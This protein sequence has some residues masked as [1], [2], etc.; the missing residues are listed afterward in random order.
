VGASAPARLVP[1]QPKQQETTPPEEASP[2]VLPEQVTAPPVVSKPVQSAVPTPT[3][4]ANEPTEAQEYVQHQYAI[5]P[6]P[7]PVLPSEWT[8]R[9]ILTVSGASLAGVIILVVSLIF[10]FSDDDSKET[11]SPNQGSVEDQAPVKND[12]ADAVVQDGGE[13]Q[14]VRPEANQSKPSE[15]AGSTPGDSQP[16]KKPPPD[17]SSLSTDEKPSLPDFIDLEPV[18]GQEQI[19]TEF[20]FVDKLKPLEDEGF[21]I[22]QAYEPKNNN[23]DWQDSNGSVDAL[24]YRLEKKPESNPFD[25]KPDQ[26]RYVFIKGSFPIVE[27]SGFLSR[28][29]EPKLDKSDSMKAYENAKITFLSSINELK[30]IGEKYYNSILQAQKENRALGEIVIQ[31]SKGNPKWEPPFNE[32]FPQAQI[33][34][35]T[36]SIRTYTKALEDN[37]KEITEIESLKN[38][39]NELKKIGTLKTLEWTNKKKPKSH[40]FYISAVRLLGKDSGFK[41]DNPISVAGK[42]N[43][44]LDCI[45]N[46]KNDFKKDGK[47]YKKDATGLTKLSDAKSKALNKP[48]KEIPLS[49]KIKICKDE[50]C[51]KVKGL[52]S[53]LIQI[54]E[55]FKIDLNDAF[56]RP[57]TKEQVVGINNSISHYERLIEALNKIKANLTSLEK[58]LKDAKEPTE[59]REGERVLLRIK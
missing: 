33:D 56:D 42:S 34:L 53:K 50:L 39:R 38:A 9:K 22:R 32:N 52:N 55:K 20:H 6:P 43:D 14:P 46:A 13:T 10:L 47:V 30:K 45:K 2:E 37:K 11:S 59:V 5:A 17:N 18:A 26:I 31:I 21:D 35:E 44:I 15:I 28:G 8:T 49:E 7:D 54:E 19:P 1:T 57:K 36:N 40:E 48:N 29:F 4:A 58:A 3:Q 16:T 41:D 27:I 23:W 12:G 51:S 25:I 24:A